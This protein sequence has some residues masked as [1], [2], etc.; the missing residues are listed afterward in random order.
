[1]PGLLPREPISSNNRCIF[2][3]GSARF[4]VEPALGGRIVSARVDA[5]E[6]LIGPSAH[7]QNFG[8]TFWTSPQADWHWPPVA[9]I[10][11]LPY[12]AS[13]E[14][15][16]FTLTS[17]RVSGAEPVMNDV[18]VEKRFSVDDEREALLV[19]Y[20]IRNLG[21]SPKRFAPWE[22]TR[23]AP[24]G[25]TFF[26]HATEPFA[27]KGGILPPLTTAAG[28]A[29]FR[30]QS[31]VAHH[32]KL[33]ASGNGWIAH[34]TPERLLLVKTFPR[35]APEAFAPNEAEIEVYAAN[36]PTE[37][38]YVEVENQGAYEAIAPG[39]ASSWA[40]R[41]YLRPLPPTVP[42]SPGPDLA[43]CVERLLL[44]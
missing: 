35:V 24:F 26:A 21:L 16:A 22:I 40:V 19:R 7:A 15:G 44:E 5:A 31:S 8:S 11:H 36:H 23:V 34:V 38:R 3:V 13:R 43:A 20:T 12:S 42:A 28:C 14:D 6:L 33:F 27:A 41:W 1:M 32:S 10:D 25:L 18:V 2:E 39:V 37:G 9:A 30:Y 17:A 4:E 29:W